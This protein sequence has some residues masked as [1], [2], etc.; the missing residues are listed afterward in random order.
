MFR[1][2]VLEYFSEIKSNVPEDFSGTFQRN[3]FFEQ[4]SNV[5][6]RFFQYKSNVPG[7][8]SGTFF[9][10]IF[11][12]YFSEIL[13]GILFKKIYGTFYFVQNI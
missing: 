8:C 4:K 7:Y 3:S 1:T 12:E 11:L 9:Q 6:E 13:R 10:N 5:Q 2:N